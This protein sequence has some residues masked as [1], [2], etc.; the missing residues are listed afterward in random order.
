MT[1]RL[2]YLLVVVAA[3]WAVTFALRSLP[4]VLFAGKDRELPGWVEKLGDIVSPV[5]IGGLII[6]SYSGLEWR[7]AWPY[8][9][10]VLTVG[11]QLWRRN[12]LVSII[13]GTV[14]YMTLVSC[15]G[16]KTRGTLELDAQHPAVSVTTVGVKFGEELVKPEEVPEILEDYDVPKDRTIH[17]LLEPEVKDLKPARY[18]MACLARAGYESPVLVTKRHGESYSTGR[19]PKVLKKKKTNIK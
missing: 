12:A 17:I 8:L 2:L 6:Y 19:K 15:C 5:I 14:L 7:T 10:G 3:G 13:A 4:F 18:L 11:L 9:A 1:S 16:C